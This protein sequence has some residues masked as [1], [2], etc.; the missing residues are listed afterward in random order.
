MKPWTY[1][2]AAEKILKLNEPQR[3]KR[4]D[5]LLA[6]AVKIQAKRLGA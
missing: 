2:T 4:A 1:R 3:L 5:R 6:H